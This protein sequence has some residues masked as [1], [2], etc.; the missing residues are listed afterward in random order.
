MTGERRR[1]IDAVAAVDVHRD[2]QPVGGR[3]F[4]DRLEHRLAV[5]LP[6]L[7]RNADLHHLRMVG[8]PLDLGDRA[9]RVLGVDP[10]VPRNRPD[11][12]GSSQRSSSQSLTAAQI[13]LLSR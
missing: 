10:M 6:R 5:G 12:S 9:L 8:Q 1:M 2:R 7:Q 13:R 3:R 11:M 4:P